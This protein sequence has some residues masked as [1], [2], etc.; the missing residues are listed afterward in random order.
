MKRQFSI[1]WIFK[2]ACVS[3]ISI[4]FREGAIHQ[5]LLLCSLCLFQGLFRKTDGKIQRKRYLNCAELETYYVF[6][7]RKTRKQIEKKRV[8]EAEI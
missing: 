6:F 2:E 1:G 7:M 3:E 5:T 8:V 4:L